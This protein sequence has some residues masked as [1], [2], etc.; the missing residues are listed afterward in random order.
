MASKTQRG[1][2]QVSG[3]TLRGIDVLNSPVLNK[4]TAFKEQEREE[5]GLVGLL[6]PSIEIIDR[7]V[8]RVLGRAH[9][10]ARRHWR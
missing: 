2:K 3:T 9:L 1:E 10:G 5:L 7:Q 4:G 8:E 6:P